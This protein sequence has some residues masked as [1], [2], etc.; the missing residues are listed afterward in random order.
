MYIIIAASYYQKR[1][2]SAAGVVREWNI[3]GFKRSESLRRNSRILMS[4]NTS[5]TS[6]Q[7]L[8]FRSQSEIWT[9]YIMYYMSLCAVYTQGFWFL[10]EFVNPA[11]FCY[12]RASSA[13]VSAKLLNCKSSFR[14]QITSRRRQA[15]NQ[16][17][18]LAGKGSLSFSIDWGC[19]SVESCGVKRR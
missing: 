7:V 16:N 13:A 6:I 18:S 3:T 5:C 11:L 15:Q 2:V 14:K 9:L 19:A 12:V 17:R 8:G 10:N 1:P 4:L